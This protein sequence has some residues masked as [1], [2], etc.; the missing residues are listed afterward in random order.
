M[1]SILDKQSVLDRI[2]QHYNLKGNADLAR[3]LGVAANTVTNWYGRNSFDLDVIYTKCVGIDFNWLLTGRGSM[4]RDDPD[5]GSVPVSCPAVP[6]I[7]ESLIYKMYKEKDTEVGQL[8]EEIGALKLKISQLEA[9]IKNN[10]NTRD[11]VETFI[12]DSLE[13]STQESFPM[14]NPATS[15]KRSSVS[16]I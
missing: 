10:D 4:L 13:S 2:K 6:P 15:S 16:K 1:G 11:L 12:P 5:N 9:K 3:F 8:K 14:R 7:D